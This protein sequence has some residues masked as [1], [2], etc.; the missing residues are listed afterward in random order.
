MQ[1]L[2]RG[3]TQADQSHFVETK[4]SL[5]IYCLLNQ[6]VSLTLSCAVGSQ[7]SFKLPGYYLSCTGQVVKMWASFGDLEREQGI[8]C[9][10]VQFALLPAWLFLR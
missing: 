4:I 5:N 9:M 2:I 3:F 6:Y 7:L 1:E 10:T 8:N